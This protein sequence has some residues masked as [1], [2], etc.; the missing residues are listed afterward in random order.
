VRRR[1]FIT[2]VGSAAA[3]WP[4]DLNASPAAIPVVGFLYGGSRPID[5]EE[6]FKQGLKESGFVEGQNVRIE[7]RWANS[8]YDKLPALATELVHRPVD[9]IAVGTPVAALA[10]KAA[11]TSI[12][13][14]FGLGSDPVKDGLVAS[15]NRPGG[16]VTGA[17]FFGNL[18]P[19]K[20]TEVLHELDPSAKVFALLLNPRNANAE[21][22]RSEAQVA[23]RSLGLQLILLDATTE[24]EIDKCFETLVERHVDAVVVTG[25]ALFYSRQK[26]IAELAMRS[27]VPTSFA[28]REQVVSGGLMSYGASISETFR[29]VGNYAGRIL[30][31]EKPAELPVLQPTKFEFV[32]NLKTAK[33]LGLIVP[34]GLLTTAD[35]VIE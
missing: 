24:S 18:L 17:T 21:L 1:D 20:R 11:T 19:A 33:M 34:A 27:R 22:E 12:P 32:I 25:D 8:Q 7:Y 30:K 28:Y 4:L 31:G 2:L 5:L 3:V 10:A 35:E 15:L 23:T 16:N 13:I 9:V 14:V 26:Q 6:A 29:Q